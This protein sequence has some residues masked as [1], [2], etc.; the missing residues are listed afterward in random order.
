MPP[1]ES[2]GPARQF[3]GLHS[4]LGPRVPAAAPRKPVEKTYGARLP[5][6]GR[7]PVGQT[8]YERRRAAK[9]AQKA[10]DGR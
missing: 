1:G 2:R 10:R 7:G 6:S 8:A 4:N 9:K 3:R 5:V